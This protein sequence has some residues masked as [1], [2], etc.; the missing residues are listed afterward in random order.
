MM[1]TANIF[2]CGFMHIYCVKNFFK[3]PT[4]EGDSVSW[5]NAKFSFVKAL[6]FMLYALVAGAVALPVFAIFVTGFCILSP[7]GIT[8]NVEGS[9]KVF[10]FIDFVKNVLVYKGYIFLMVLSYYL[11][12]TSQVFLDQNATIG[13]FIAILIV[14]FAMH[15]YEQKIP[16][17]DANMTEGEAPYTK[18]ELVGEG[19]AEETATP[20][21]VPSE[22]LGGLTETPLT[23][24]P[25][26]PTQQPE[27]QP[28]IQQQVA[29]KRRPSTSRKSRR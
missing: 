9:D 3:T 28:P 26:N 21:P 5:S 13:I 7:I 16:E 10:K 25:I 4:P 12:K 24:P 17:N 29:G 23:P 19:G 8:F 18:A 20:T 6:M 15:L 11:I 27:Q 14:A 2:L 22:N 1:F